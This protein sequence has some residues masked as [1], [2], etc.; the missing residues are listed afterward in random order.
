MKLLIELHYDID[1]IE[2]AKKIRDD[3]LL[4]LKY[5]PNTVYVLNKNQDNMSWELLSSE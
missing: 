1:D 5:T 3:I 2:E 4:R